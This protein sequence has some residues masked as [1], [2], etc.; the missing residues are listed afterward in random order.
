MA[1]IVGINIPDNKQIS[2]AL[3]YIYGVGL[4][5]SRKVL[6]EAN[7]EAG[8]RAKDLTADEVSR[9][10]EI[11]EKNFK[12]CCRCCHNVGISEEHN[13]KRYAIF[14]KNYDHKSWSPNF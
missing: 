3:T 5:S 12:K 6:K 7:I 8:K 11:I 13:K 1:R 9:L 14:R 2:I 10:K 4:A